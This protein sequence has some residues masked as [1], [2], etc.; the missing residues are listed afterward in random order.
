MQ[1]NLRADLPLIHS[2]LIIFYISEEF[3]QGIN[4]EFS[5]F[6]G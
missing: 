4:L 3:F 6:T 1:G 5:G 2:K